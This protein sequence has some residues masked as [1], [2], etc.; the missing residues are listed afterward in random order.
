MAVGTYNATAFFA[1]DT[2]Y[3]SASHTAVITI[4]TLA[5][6]SFA[7]VSAGLYHTCAIQSDGA[8]GCWGFN[9]VGQAT[10]PAGTFTQISAGYYH[11]CGVRS[12]GTLACWGD[13]TYGQATPPTGLYRQA[14]AGALHPAGFKVR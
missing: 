7:Q 9:S 14:G 3:A 10:P 13:N 4:T 11:T 2:N 8:V 12:D 5:V 6:G 1:G